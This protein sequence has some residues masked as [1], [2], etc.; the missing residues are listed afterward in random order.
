MKTKKGYVEFSMTAIIVIIIG[1][2]ILALAINFI[3]QKLNNDCSQKD[4][5]NGLCECVETC[6]D[7]CA[8]VGCVIPDECY[9]ENDYHKYI[10]FDNCY[11]YKPKSQC[12]L[13]IENK[14]NKIK[15]FDEECVCEEIDIYEKE[16][17]SEEDKCWT[18][19]DTRGSF[20]NCDA[21]FCW[22]NV[23]NFC[24]NIFL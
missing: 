1:V 21:E 13:Y 14:E 9:S 15:D 3:S 2:I 7:K 23:Y 24:Y 18:R 19:Q 5:D 22:I 16:I 4:I 20:G 12:Q 11:E 10:D 6:E 17:L 8:D